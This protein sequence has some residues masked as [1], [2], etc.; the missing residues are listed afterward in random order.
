LAASQVL[1]EVANSY[2]KSI[3]A[4]SSEFINYEN[5]KKKA[6]EVLDDVKAKETDP[7]LLRFYNTR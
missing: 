5:V 2:G 6:Q 3:L 7:N 4:T 1:A